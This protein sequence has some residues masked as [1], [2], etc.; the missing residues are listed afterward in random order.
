MSGCGQ[1]NPVKKAPPGVI[2][3]AI[4]AGAAG[5]GSFAPDGTPVVYLRRRIRK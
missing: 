2:R 3:A 5:N 1:G 4:L